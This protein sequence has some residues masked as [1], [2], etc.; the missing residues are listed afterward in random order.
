M[1]KQSLKRDTL[2]EPDIQIAELRLQVAVHRAQELQHAVKTDRRHF[3]DTM[4]LD[5]TRNLDQNLDDDT[6]I[7]EETI[8]R[9]VPD[10]EMDLAI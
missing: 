7:I 6:I 2:M 1:K 9:I 8:I 5:L 4:L 10:D 3:D